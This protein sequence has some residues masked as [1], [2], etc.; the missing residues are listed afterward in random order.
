M[1]QQN[2]KL[3]N[4][5]LANSVSLEYTRQVCH[6]FQDSRKISVCTQGG[7]ESGKDFVRFSVPFL[8][9]RISDVR[10]AF[11]Y[12]TRNTN[13]KSWIQDIRLKSVSFFISHFLFH[14]QS[15]NTPRSDQERKEMTSRELSYLELL[16]RIHFRFMW[17][18]S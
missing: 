11:N 8:E 14:S 9:G 1:K 10:A 13:F 16:F 4:F 6:L 18:I 5:S 17:I 7:R 3:A 15:Y 12:P 2:K